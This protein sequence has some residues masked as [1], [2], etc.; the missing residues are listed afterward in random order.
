MEQKQKVGMSGL[1]WFL[2][3]VGILV[4]TSFIAL[5]PIC[6]SLIEEDSS[7]GNA[8]TASAPTK[9]ENGAIVTTVCKKVEIQEETEYLIQ[10]K[11]DQL[12]M[13]A[14]TTTT[15][16]ADDPTNLEENCRIESSLYQGLAGFQY[17]CRVEGTDAIVE[18]R[19]QMKDFQNDEIP[20]PFDVHQTVPKLKDEMTLAGFMCE[21]R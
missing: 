7:T 20:I 8:P 4:F 19:L 11:E 16:Y 12:V 10:S 6:R 1:N 13:L 15:H 17:Q 21:Q 5:P 18:S 9:E 3:I 14:K 2:S